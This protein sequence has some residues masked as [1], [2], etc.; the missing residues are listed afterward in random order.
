LH[1]RKEL[2]SIERR[3]EVKPEITD[4]TLNPVAHSNGMESCERSTLSNLKELNALSDC[5]VFRGVSKHDV[6]VL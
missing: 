4:S 3:V 6:S 5:P 2:F 1:F